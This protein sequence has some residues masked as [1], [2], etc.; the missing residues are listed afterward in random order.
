MTTRLISAALAIV[1]LFATTSVTFAQNATAD[2]M[3]QIDA[4]TCRDLLIRS[5][6]EREFV[7]IFM[8]GY[9]SGRMS[10]MTFDAPALTLATD[11]VIDGCIS[12]P[13]ASLLS[14]FESARS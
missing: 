7:I 6:D 3:M 11:A 9:M 14:V 13:D 8:H 12:D 2:G 10:E 4:F 1:G 5:G